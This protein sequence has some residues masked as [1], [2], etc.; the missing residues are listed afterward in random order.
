MKNKTGKF[1]LAICA[2]KDNFQFTLRTLP[3]FGEKIKFRFMLI[4][5]LKISQA[6][7]LSFCKTFRHLVVEKIP[8]IQNVK[9]SA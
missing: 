2:S 9:A 8:L 7:D 3:E 6:M 4:M 1:H 5:P